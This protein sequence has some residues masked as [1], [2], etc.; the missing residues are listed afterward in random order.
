MAALLGGVFS[1]SAE[2]VLASDTPAAE[3]TRTKLLKLKVTLNA[4]NVSLRELLKEVAAQV[5]MQSE[6][7]IMWTYAPDVV[8]TQPIT[9]SCSGKDVETVLAELCKLAGIG[10]IVVSKDDHKHDGWIRITRGPE[11]G[12]GKYPDDTP[13]PTI[14]DPDEMK[15]AARL[16]TAKEL[17]E[18]G[19]EADA[20]AVLKLIMDKHPKTKAAAEAKLL[21]EKL[22]K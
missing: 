4:K 22:T 5:E 1:A 2:H 14:D 7:P 21:L 6:K 12:Y 19:K 3:R 11:R 8:A 17:L 16:K 20:K 9:Y 10:Y 18:T 13:A 15:A